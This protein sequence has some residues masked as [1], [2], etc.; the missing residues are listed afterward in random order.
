MPA[1]VTLVLIDFEFDF[2]FDVH[3]T[4]TCNGPE[5]SSNFATFLRT[6]AGIGHHRLQFGKLTP[7]DIIH[8]ASH[9]HTYK[10]ASVCMIF[11]A[12]SYTA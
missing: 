3:Y 8:K 7:L 12:A 5:S 1:S 10:N 6:V 2:E 11:C 4:I 9:R